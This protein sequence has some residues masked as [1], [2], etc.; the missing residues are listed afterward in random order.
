MKNSSDK[1]VVRPKVVKSKVANE[2]NVDAKKRINKKT[3]LV[4]NVKSSMKKSKT[5][6][7]DNVTKENEVDDGTF[8]GRLSR[9]ASKAFGDAYARALKLR[10][11]VLIA[12]NGQ[13]GEIHAD[14]TFKVIREIKAPT[15]VKM[16]AVRYRAKPRQ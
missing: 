11:H 6:N 3:I 2:A 15:L 10:G 14:G 13:L 1:P 12:K 4:A 5:V 9:M 16:G 7:N 8:G